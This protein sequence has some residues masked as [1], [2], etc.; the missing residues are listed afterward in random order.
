MV[1]VSSARGHLDATLVVDEGVPNGAV[2]VGWLTP[3]A[4][5]NALIEAGSTVTEVTVEAR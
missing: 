3:G 1:R 5:A 2:A 4:P